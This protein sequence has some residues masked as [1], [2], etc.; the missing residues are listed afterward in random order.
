MDLQRQALINRMRAAA[1]ENAKKREE[2]AAT[3]QAK[4]KF[5]M[6]LSPVAGAGIS[7]SPVP[8]PSLS[9]VKEMQ[10]PATVQGQVQEP[11]PRAAQFQGNITL[12]E[13]QLMAVEFA[14]NKK[15]FCLIGAAGTGKTTTVKR[16]VEELMMHI[17][18]NK[19][20][21]KIALVSFTNR[22]VR[23]IQKA[24]ASIGASGLCATIHS[25]LAFKPE[26]YEKFDDKGNMSKGMEF[27]PTFTAENPLKE[28]EL[29]VIDESS[30]VDTR[31][32]KQLKDACPN[33][34]FIFIGDLNQL[35]PVFGDAILGFKL[36]ELPVVELTQVYR[37]AME[38][39]IIAFQ[40]NYVLRGFLPTNA[41]IEK[42]TEEAKGLH[43]HAMKQF[44]AD[45]YTV[46]RSFASFFKKEKAAGKWNPEEDVILIPYNKG[47]G[48]TLMNLFIAEF[49]GKEREAEVYE[50]IAGF[51]KQYFAVGDF[52]VWDKREMFI[53]KIYNNP[54]YVGK[55]PNPHS[56]DL[57]RF[58]HYSEGVKVHELLGN[59]L[60][61]GSQEFSQLLS[62]ME[63]EKEEELK[64][65]ASHIIE[66]EG[67]DLGQDG[68][69]IHT[70]L[71]KTRG[72][73][74]KLLFG[75]AITIH[76]SQGSE[77]R[78]VYLI[79][80][81]HHAPML[82]RE[83]L[84]TGMTRAREELYVIYS[85]N[86]TTGAKNS[87]VIKAIQKQDIKGRT[88]QDKIQTFKGKFQEYSATMN[89]G[90]TYRSQ[91]SQQGKGEE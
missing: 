21:D 35:P 73:I 22:A 45:E 64:N 31:L 36:A 85:P 48:T 81:R 4:N 61:F 8:V 47:V 26:Y 77:W 66:L 24:V 17:P 87:S 84:Y 5:A 1:A 13:K 9:A 63:N 70:A 7:S 6:E 41:E 71:I 59:E 50:I 42:I 89:G 14:R 18:A 62:A 49:L 51:E 83:L 10:V 72:D 69:P 68:K 46:C 37:Q 11:S 56:K 44:V 23:N 3:L 32:F 43:F 57:N 16:I 53:T 91:Q 52:V 75:Y 27:I 74:N 86:T 30:M 80:T 2:E 78:K 65:Q 15:P 29:V 25:L 67:R 20:F 34:M 76:K 90:K 60:D 28:M 39:P 12:N 33:A 55:K 40:H 19:R 88:W 54:G 38:S 79:I 58:G 82:S